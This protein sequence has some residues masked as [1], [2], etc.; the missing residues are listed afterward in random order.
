MVEIRPITTNEGERFLR[1]LCSVF[2]L[3][4]KRAESI[5]FTE[6]LFDLDRKWALFE[7]GRMTSIL[8]TVPLRFGWGDAIGIAGVATEPDRQ[9]QGLAAQLL[10][11]VLRQSKHANEGAAFLFAKDPRVYERVG[12]KTVDSVIRGV[13][14][15]DRPHERHRPL[16]LEEVQVV[17]DEWSERDPGRLR[18]DAKRWR[19]W[20]WNLRVCTE[21]EGGYACVEGTTV[22]ELVAD[23]CP[24]DG[25]GLGPNVEWLGLQTMAAKV[26]LELISPQFELHLMAFGAPAVPQM[27]LTDQF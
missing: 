7:A 25:W 24:A 19:Y 4:Y 22:R 14:R 8:T 26:Q 21:V 18:R 1:L 9:G 27:F 20:K 6:P 10:I 23:P 2:H 11:E 12:F 13:V 5:F 16:A 17:Y 15:D 3:D